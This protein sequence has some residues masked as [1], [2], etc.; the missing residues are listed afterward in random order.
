MLTAFFG[1]NQYGGH[2][3]PYPGGIFQVTRDTKTIERIL[4]EAGSE[5]R[6]R[7]P[8][9][10]CPGPSALH[11]LFVGSAP[12]HKRRAVREHIARCAHCSQVVKG[13]LTDDH[14]P[15][16]QADVD[17]DLMGALERIPALLGR[18]PDRYAATGATSLSE[19]LAGWISPLRLRPTFGAAAAAVLLGALLIVLYRPSA[20]LEIHQVFYGEQEHLTRSSAPQ[21][22]SQDAVLRS[23]DRFYLTVEP[24]APSFIYVVAFSSQSRLVQ[25]FPR[26]DLGPPNP[27]R[28]GVL[29]A[30]PAE[31]AWTL[32]DHPG[33]E[34]VFLLASLRPA[35][36]LDGM[37]SEMGRVGASLPHREA[38]RR[39]KDL[40]S[41]RFDAVEVLSFEHR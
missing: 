34:T 12:R 41:E 20:P 37:L 40:L 15:A 9:G 31:K 7:T 30:I 14:V 38:E 2:G 23:G 24:T 33:T 28:A 5:E 3:P 18:R 29:Q 10:P 4:L 16:G 27:L 35:G 13:F 21:P 6:E 22:L 25:L 19:R 39:M 11:E 1:L 26:P 17:A 32:D 36:G 8:L